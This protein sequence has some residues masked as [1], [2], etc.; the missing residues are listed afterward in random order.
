MD[1]SAGALPICLKFCMAFRPDLRQVFSYFGGIA[2]GMADFWAST[3]R[4]MAAFRDMLLAEALGK[5][6]FVGLCAYLD[7]NQGGTNRNGYTRELVTLHA[8]TYAYDR[9][10][11]L[12]PLLI[13][14][15]GFSPVGHTNLVFDTTSGFISR[16]VP[17]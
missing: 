14:L 11:Y 8:Q 9:L 10:A 5:M 6:L 4:H 16:C 3:E 15:G 7:V 12:R 13:F 1:F 17:A 2:P